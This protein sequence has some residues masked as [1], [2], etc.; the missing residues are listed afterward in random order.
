MSTPW[1]ISNAWQ[2][3][4]S[5]IETYQQQKFIETEEFFQTQ[6]IIW[7]VRQLPFSSS[8]FQIRDIKVDIA[9]GITPAQNKKFRKSTLA[10]F[11]SIQNRPEQ[12]NLK[13]WCAYRHL[14]LGVPPP[15]YFWDE[16]N[17]NC[18]FLSENK[19]GTI[20]QKPC[21]YIVV[22]TID[23][24]DFYCVRQHEW[25]VSTFRDD[26]FPLI[27][28]THVTEYSD[29]DPAAGVE[30]TDNCE[31][32]TRPNA[33]KKKT[34]V[35]N[36]TSVFSPLVS[37]KVLL[38]TRVRS[39]YMVDIIN[40]STLSCVERQR[41][42]QAT[43]VKKGQM[44]QPR[45]IYR[46]LDV[47]NNCR[48]NIMWNDNKLQYMYTNGGPKH[49]RLTCNAFESELGFLKSVT[50]LNLL[51]GHF[52]H[53]T[54]PLLCPCY[55]MPV[56]DYSLQ[57]YI[58][59]LYDEIQ[60]MS[61][62]IQQYFTDFLRAYPM[63]LEEGVGPDG[64]R[65][66]FLLACELQA[67]IYLKAYNSVNTPHPSLYPRMTST[68]TSTSTSN[69]T[70]IPISTPTLT[71]TT[72]PLHSSLPATSSPNPSLPSPSLPAMVPQ[73]ESENKRSLPS[74][75]PLPP[76]TVSVTEVSAHTHSPDTTDYN[77]ANNKNT[78]TGDHLQTNCVFEWADTETWQSNLSP[79]LY[80]DPNTPSGTSKTK[81]VRKSPSSMPFRGQHNLWR[82]RYN[83]G[84]PK[85]DFAVA[86]P[87][88]LIQVI[89][90]ITF[91]SRKQSE[92]ARSVPY[93]PPPAPMPYQYVQL[94]HDFPLCKQIPRTEVPAFLQQLEDPP[95]LAVFTIDYDDFVAVQSHSWKWR[96]AHDKRSF[97]LVTDKADESQCKTI[98]ETIHE[99][100]GL[101]TQ[102]PLHC[103]VV[104]TKTMFYHENAYITDN[105][106]ANILFKHPN[107]DK[108]E[109][110]SFIQRSTTYK[111]KADFLASAS[112]S[113]SPSRKKRY[114][115]PHPYK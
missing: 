111:T 46:S 109:R 68:S 65:Q 29:V 67:S 36:Q 41:L 13:Q 106:R 113:A 48:N 66:R 102:P 40:E 93:V 28:I 87:D 43:T 37:R 100:L 94:C 11:E 18:C 110:L 83:H 70:S 58:K 45:S 17:T 14:Q 78:H 24:D 101:S 86:I 7:R 91:S 1:P 5:D 10:L 79:S 35:N 80:L 49:T 4:Y 95:Y 30:T 73:V 90:S 33:K 19:K 72:I 61:S 71:S 9:F 108:M 23:Y 89:R 8:P 107:S 52:I 114:T 31:S 64:P 69:S 59:K 60:Y 50:N 3:R 76:L 63:S 82:I 57:L 105:R 55:T 98:A 96:Q 115:P 62:D 34:N 16:E 51:G 22:L 26:E 74:P 85:V 81:R 20:F 88:Y 103:A 21:A 6:D 92:L 54:H 104:S 42:T 32:K 75:S 38:N 27:V 56:V 25:K 39:A 53:A 12:P 97:E 77:F 99:S 84:D 2:S 44:Y 112:E 47:T 15:G